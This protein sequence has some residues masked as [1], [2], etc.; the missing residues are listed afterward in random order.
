MTALGTA[1]GINMWQALVFDVLC[2]RNSTDWEKIAPIYWHYWCLFPSLYVHIWCIILKSCVTYKIMVTTSSGWTHRSCSNCSSGS[3][4]LW[5]LIKFSF[6]WR[7]KLNSRT[8]IRSNSINIKYNIFDIKCINCNQARR[9]QASGP[10]A[11]VSTNLKY[12]WC[13]C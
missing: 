8:F 13:Y 3:R 6:L 2:P 11:L 7:G 1:K 9:L 12:S 5:W 4:N 10:S